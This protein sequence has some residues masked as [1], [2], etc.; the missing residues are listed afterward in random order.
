MARGLGEAIECTRRGA[1]AAA[2]EPRDRALG[3]HHALRKLGLAQTGTHA[4]LRHRRREREFLLQR[5][6]FPADLWIL[7]EL[8]LQAAELAHFTSLARC[9]AISGSRGGAF[10]VFF[11]KTRCADPSV[12]R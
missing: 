9:R 7:Q 1:A 12:L 8:F 10:C 2:F 3:R 4:C 6:I 11:T 5:I